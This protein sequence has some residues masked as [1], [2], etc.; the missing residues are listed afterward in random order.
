MV[1]NCFGMLIAE[2]VSA[3]QGIPLVTL[4]IFALSLYPVGIMLGGS[5][6][7]CCDEED[8]IRC[9]PCIKIDVSGSTGA[10]IF[11]N[12][13]CGT[14]CEDL[15]GSLI[16]YNTSHCCKETKKIARNYYC[17]WRGYNYIYRGFPSNGRISGMFNNLWAYYIDLLTDEQKLN[18]GYCSYYFE[19]ASSYCYKKDD[20]K[21]YKENKPPIAAI[22]VV[23]GVKSKLD[24]QTALI[25]VNVVGSVW[26]GGQPGFCGVFINTCMNLMGWS[27][28]TDWGG[29]KYS[30]T[31]I[32]GT[33]VPSG[34]TMENLYVTTSFCDT[35][36]APIARDCSGTVTTSV[37]VNPILDNSEN[38][39]RLQDPVL[40]CAKPYPGYEREEVK[41]TGTIFDDYGLTQYSVSIS[42]FESIYC[43]HQSGWDM[44]C[45]VAFSEHPCDCSQWD[46]RYWDP[47]NEC[48][49][50]D[51]ECCNYNKCHKSPVPPNCDAFNTT[52]TLDFA[53][54]P[55]GID[56]LCAPYCG[57][58]T[59]L[60]DQDGNPIPNI[61]GVRPY[62]VSQ[63]MEGVSCG[64][65]GWAV[66]CEDIGYEPVDSSAPYICLL[67]GEYICPN[68]KCDGDSICPCEPNNNVTQLCYRGTRAAFM[69]AGCETNCGT[70]NPFNIVLGYARYNYNSPPLPN[71]SFI[72][73]FTWSDWDLTYPYE[74]GLCVFDEDN[75]KVYLSS[76]DCCT[77]DP[78]ALPNIIETES[79][80]LYRDFPGVGIDVDSLPGCG[81]SNI[82]VEVNYS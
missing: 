76:Y 1:F 7:G 42:G 27:M 22:V 23:N 54:F 45:S 60:T 33:V 15:D 46:G 34:S 20:G 69:V 80:C 32:W 31:A 56:S 38:Y 19:S 57:Y 3:P 9:P 81:G 50:P 44:D 29:L 78:R 51:S 41:V 62:R 70:M 49:T 66:A 65:G 77:D 48:P 67:E 68:A 12:V 35:K 6:C 11:S 25:P 75:E 61:S 4:L 63:T 47:I 26:T 10:G 64:G 55:S 30:P 5:S 82:T 59:S 43:A 39:P 28:Y 8:P 21:Y 73:I 36:T 17:D 58:Y 13:E 16:L 71:H 24:R 74:T 18:N 53:S 37:I 40:C 79:Y 2:I 14:K 52:I 72:G